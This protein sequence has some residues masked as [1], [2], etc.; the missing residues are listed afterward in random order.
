MSGLHQFVPTFEPGAVGSHAIEVQRLMRS[1]GV[2]SEI[3]AEHV[4]P[5]FSGR[6]RRFTEYGSGRRRRTDDVLVYQ[7][8]IGSVVADFVADR[9][10]RLVLNHHNL[11][12]VALLEVWEP[13]ATFGVT[14]GATQL[15]QLAGRVD[16]GVAVSAYNER[17]LM[18]AGYATTEV[19]PILL[20]LGAFAGEADPATE[21]R[22][23]AAKSGGGSDWLFVGRIAANKCQHDVVKAFAAFRRMCDSRARLHLVGGS[24]SGAYREA[25]LN[26]VIALGLEGAVEL[27]GPVS[28]AAL[29]AY[30]R[31]ADVYVCLS[32]HEGFCVPLLEA[33]HHGVP[34]VAFAAAAVPETLASAGVLL[35]AKDP[36]TVAIAV[37]RVLQPDVRAALSEAGARR[38][39]DFA[40]ARTRARWLE[41]L[42]WP[43]R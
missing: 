36:V 25:L 22:L 37:D 24:T 32:E 12:P 10:E 29:I 26:F 31:A 34:I 21:A 30:Y 38:L 13:A 18:R 7:M 16:L 2:D 40:L 14:W 41:A 23:E 9:R 8:A 15:R 11:T 35:P 6:A 19:A 1:L 27:S 3:Y 33:M 43:S 5:S 20:D 28:H 42:G 39:A 4:H 17:E